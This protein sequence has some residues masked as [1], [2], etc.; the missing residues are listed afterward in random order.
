MS[1][2]QFQNVVQS[3]EEYIS[4][5][6]RILCPGQMYIF[7]FSFEV[8]D[9]LPPSS[10]LHKSAPSRVR[11]AH[12]QLPPSLGDATISGLGGKLRDDFASAGCRI[13]YSI[14]FQLTHYN[15][16]SGK[17]E[18]LFVKRQQLRMKPA[19]DEICP[20]QHLDSLPRSEYCMRGEKTIYS[21]REK[22]AIGRLSV[23]VQE[24]VRIWLP[25]RDPNLLISQTVRISLFY[26]PCGSLPLEPPDL[27]SFESQIIATT[28]Y[29][30]RKND[31]YQPIERRHFFGQPT[32]FHDKQFTPITRPISSIPWDLSETGAYTTSLQVPV[33]LPRE[34]FIPTFYSCLISRTYTLKCKHKF[35]S[36][37]WNI[38]ALSL[39]YHLRRT[40]S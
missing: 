20:I 7:P 33:T 34:N 14:K 24:P 21:E 9:I 13:S 30:T 40:I 10:C 36:W 29:T 4:P 35:L 8:L 3:V 32:N 17:Q 16:L 25:S 15:P 38:F 22:V 18:M 39:D 1:H 27:D 37:S 12:L 19:L 5:N 26:Q 11:V 31:N 28:F 2:H 23:T 6:P